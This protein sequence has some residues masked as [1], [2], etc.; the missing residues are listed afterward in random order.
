MD[1]EQPVNIK[2][3]DLRAQISWTPGTTLAQVERQVIEKALSYFRGVKAVTARSLNMD[4]KTLERRLQEYGAADDARR[5]I[6]EEEQRKKKD[7]LRRARGIPSGASFMPHAGMDSEPEKFRS[8]EP[9]GNVKPKETDNLSEPKTREALRP[10]G[11]KPSGKGKG[12]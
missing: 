10:Q 8:F 1:M 11:N 3:M 5:E 4:I 2:H 7:Y 12:R 9:E 6:L